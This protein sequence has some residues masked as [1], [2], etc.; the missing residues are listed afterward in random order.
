MADVQKR[1]TSI[2]YGWRERDVAAVAARLIYE[3]KAVAKYG[4][5]T[6]R[7]D[8][9]RL[10][11]FLYKRNEIGKTKIQK[12]EMISIQK[13]KE[14][15][16]FLRDFFDIMDVPEDDDGLVG[17][18]ISKFE[19]QAEHY[20]NLLGK[21][22]GKN[23]PDKGKVLEAKE[24]LTDLL[25]AKTDNIALVNKL[26]QMEDKLE[27]MQEDMEA[28]EDFFKSQVAT[29]DEAAELESFLRADL[30]YLQNEDELNNA[31]NKIRLVVNINPKKEYFDYQDL[32]KLNDYMKVVRDGHNK[33]LDKKR[34]EILEIVRQ[35][36]E[37][38]HKGDK[39]DSQ[40]GEIIKKTDDFYSQKKKEIS[41][42]ESLRILDGF[43]PGLWSVKDDAVKDINSIENSKMEVSTGKKD[44]DEDDRVK[45][46]GEVLQT[47]R[48]KHIKKAYRQA[49]F[50]AK[51]LENENE[52]RDYLKTVE[53]NLMS[54]LGDCDGIEIN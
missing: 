31:L 7:A 52:I 53:K 42:T 23:Y 51:T 14:A 22:E 30:D 46:T 47:Q 38:I 44:K 34:E 33:L 27:D 15:R 10:P 20:N 3:Q 54:L 39:Y 5:E 45:E 24:T 17:F 21:Y 12:R 9:I 18:I 11:E 43:I 50:P 29:F 8:D 32:P 1:F 35:C 13:I 26:I 2:P 41:Q 49:L 28:I 37:E 19:N 4:G 25:Y 40:I 36:M 48:K 6:I 16:E